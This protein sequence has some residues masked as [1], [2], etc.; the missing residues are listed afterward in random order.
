MPNWCWNHLQIEG[1]ESQLLEAL[2]LLK[3][4]GKEELTFNLAKPQPPNLFNDSLSFAEMK[5]LDAKGIPNWYN[6]NI[7]NWGTK[8][9]AYNSYISME[10][11][12][13]DISFET[14]WSPPTEWFYS[15]VEQLQ[16]KQ[17]EV[18]AILKYSEEG[19]GFCGAYLMEGDYEVF[20]YDGEIK[21]I[22]NGVGLDVTYDSNIGK[23]RNSKGRF[24]NSMDVVSDFDYGA[25]L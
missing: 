6:W 20:D 1:D 7:Q 4:D 12:L 19:M 14:A 23:Y 8:W 24:V 10:S 18:R 22:Q 15:L 16:S 11:D 3:E 21:L 25:D 2:K 9:D 13:L 17:I 5:E